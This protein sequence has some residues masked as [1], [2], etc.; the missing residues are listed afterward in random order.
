MLKSHCLVIASFPE[1]T[2]SFAGKFCCI[3]RSVTGRYELAVELVGDTWILHQW[4]L[5]KPNGLPHDLVLLFVTSTRAVMIAL[6]QYLYER[7][8]RTTWSFILIIDHWLY[9]SRFL[10]F[11]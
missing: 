1:G 10:T 6:T 7:L 9:T 11:L 3:L 4:H 5:M 8:C 2:K